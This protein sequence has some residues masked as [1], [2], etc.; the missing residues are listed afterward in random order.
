MSKS[1]GPVRSETARAVAGTR[2]KLVLAFLILPAL[3][4]AAFLFILYLAT[5]W[6]YPPG[7]EWVSRWSP[8]DLLLAGLIVLGAYVVVCALL[9]WRLAARWLWEPAARVLN[10]LEEADST[11][12]LAK[13]GPPSD[14]P[15]L[16]YRIELAA[17]RRRSAAEGTRE[18]DDVRSAVGRLSQEIERMGV[19]RFDRD[20]SDAKGPLEPLG[21]SLA[22]CCTE[23][24]GFINGCSEVVSQITATLR[25]AQERS[26]GLADRAESAFV[27]HSEMSLGVKEFTKRVSEAVNIAALEAR[28]GDHDAGEALGPV[29][30]A[31]D[32]YSRSLD[33]ISDKDSGGNE[34]A[35]DAKRLADEATVIALNA[36]IEASR[37]GSADLES[38]AEN[39]RRLAEG[40]MELGEKVDALSKG[41]VEGVRDAAAGLEGLRS[42][43]YAWLKETRAVESR[44][45]EAAEELRGFL[46]SVGDMTASLAGGV[47]KVAG[48][49]EAASSEAQSAKR[50]VDEALGEM[51]A[52][53]RRLGGQDA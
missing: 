25:K 14:I 48:L 12:E 26:S 1:E 50:A 8:G 45:A 17:D 6:P 27:G 36:A 53:K 16:F 10:V 13:A 2:L 34:A 23:L 47:E 42:R 46:G 41:Y 9:V 18:M 33:R 35:A 51:E 43:L 21:R 30:R 31:A 29:A 7:F 32:E 19:R 3:F 24:S 38:L 40:A 5:H 22:E 39:A 15:Q 11:G 44:R 37:S 20:F 28:G 4:A 49:S 52:L